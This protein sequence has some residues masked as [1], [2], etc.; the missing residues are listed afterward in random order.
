[1]RYTP[2]NHII[3][4]QNNFVF[5]RNEKY[6]NKTIFIFMMKI[7]FFIYAFLLNYLLYLPVNVIYAYFGIKKIIIF[8]NVLD[9]WDSESDE[10][11]ALLYRVSLKLKLNYIYII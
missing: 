6:K 2:L 3:I 4:I 10:F 1:M 5:L 7:S 8:M 11:E 9:L